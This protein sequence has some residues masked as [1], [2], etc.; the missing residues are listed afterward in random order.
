MA[1]ETINELHDRGVN[2]SLTE[3]DI[4]TTTMMGRALFGIVAVF[5]QLCVGTI[6]DN[7]RRGLKHEFGPVRWKCG[8]TG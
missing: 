1:V 7:A 5:A 6:R 3:P 4:D 8:P 2:Q